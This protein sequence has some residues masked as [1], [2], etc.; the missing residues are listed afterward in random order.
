MPHLVIDLGTMNERLSEALPVIV[1]HSSTNLLG[2]WSE[3]K[4]YQQE[5]LRQFQQAQ[6]QAASEVPMTWEEYQDVL[7]RRIGGPGYLGLYSGGWH[8]Q[9]VTEAR[10][11]SKKVFF[12]INNLLFNTKE[13]RLAANNLRRIRAA[14]IENGPSI[15][16][17]EGT[18]AALALTLVYARPNFSDIPATIQNDMAT[19]GPLFVAEL[20]NALQD[21]F[22]RSDYV[23]WSDVWRRKYRALERKLG[24]RNGESGTT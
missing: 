14:Y 1:R 18:K 8:V 7:N 10:T 13:M 11:R 23:D 2:R 16:T 24:L 9:A 20:Q 4:P 6:P 17:S 15:E 22:E 19:L 12:V 21:A 3:L 5:A